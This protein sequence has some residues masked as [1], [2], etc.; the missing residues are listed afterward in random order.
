[1]KVNWRRLW[2][3]HWA[4]IIGLCLFFPSG[5]LNNASHTDTHTEHPLTH[6][7]FT[8]YKPQGLMTSS[9]SRKLVYNCTLCVGGCHWGRWW[10]SPGR[11]Q[12]SAWW[13]ISQGRRRFIAIGSHRK[14]HSNLYSKIEKKLQ[15]YSFIFK[16]NQ[17]TFQ[18]N[19]SWS[20]GPRFVECL[21]DDSIDSLKRPQEKTLIRFGYCIR[22][23]LGS[24][25]N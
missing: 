4:S 25:F 2:I 9:V 23:P 19:V 12:W 11:K 3:I 10:S 1:M 8:V 14:F 16:R 17:A 7:Q 21:C 20:R 15:S 24:C 6:I 18:F 5:S 13:K 22:V